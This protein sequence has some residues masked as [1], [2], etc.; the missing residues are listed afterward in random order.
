MFSL[1]MNSQPHH[2][3]S[4]D[5]RLLN[6][7]SDRKAAQA[8]SLAVVKSLKPNAEVGS[9]GM[10]ARSIEKLENQPGRTFEGV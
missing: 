10:Y 5:P 3:P 4:P 6:P 2:I 9:A 7:G 1:R 8:G